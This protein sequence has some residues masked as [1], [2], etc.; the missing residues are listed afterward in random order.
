MKGLTALATRAVPARH[1]QGRRARLPLARLRDVGLPLLLTRLL[2]V[3][4]TLTAPQWRWTVPDPGRFLSPA[5]PVGSALLSRWYRWDAAWYLRI[6]GNGPQMGYSQYTENAAHNYGAFAFFPLYPLAVRVAAIAVPGALAAV[7]AGGIPRAR[8]LVAAI[9][10]ANM[11]F[12]LAL[13]ALYALARARAGP[14]AARRAIW[15]LCLF[16]TT[17]FFSAPYSESLFF[18]WVV[19]FFLALERGRWLQAG[20]CGALAAATRS[21]GVAL[22]VPYLVCYWQQGWSRPSP[23]NG[24]VQPSH[25][26]GRAAHP[27]LTGRGGSRRGGALR[28]RLGALWPV[29]LIPL[30]LL[31]YM[32]YLKLAWGDPLLFREAEKAWGRSLAAPWVG[33]VDGLTW[34]LRPWPHLPQQNWRGLTDALYALVF[35]GLTALAWPQMGWVDRAYAIVFWLFVLCEPQ[36][37]DPHYPDTLLSMARF[38]LL[39][40]PLWLWLARSRRRTLLMAL[41]S[42]V[43]LLVYAGRWV[44]GGWIG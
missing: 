24:R 22:A 11:A 33:I 31:G 40:P 25:F 16:P 18:L 15:L 7:P 12:V 20:L 9:V 17:V 6:A 39:L 43:A 2:L 19:L 23:P 13:V 38:L 42:A 35:L 1:A 8:L 44:N 36:I 41:P 26:V 14:A 21:F 10:V 32:A 30:G 37:S 34:S 4:V 28:G 27:T 5:P 3:L 29:T